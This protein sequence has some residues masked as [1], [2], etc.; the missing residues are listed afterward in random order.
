MKRNIFLFAFISTL[1]MGC[2]K[3][4]GASSLD[5]NTALITVKDEA[6]ASIPLTVIYAFSDFSWQTNA[7]K[8]DF[9]EWTKTTD[10][11]GLT[12]FDNLN[13]DLLVQFNTLMSQNPMMP[14][15]KFKFR[16]GVFHFVILHKK[17]PFTTTVVFEKGEQRKFVITLK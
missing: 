2:S 8:T 6:G 13:D 5:R 11:K 15:S 17:K 10:E 7:Q 14:E 1:L 12:H 16:E 4:D 9:A 3:D